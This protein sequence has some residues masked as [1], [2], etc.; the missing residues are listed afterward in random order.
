MMVHK[1]WSTKNRSTILNSDW[2]QRQ[3]TRVENG[4]SGAIKT[5]QSDGN[6]HGKQRTRDWGSTTK[7]PRRWQ[8]GE[9]LRVEAVW[10]H[11]RRLKQWQDVWDTGGYSGELRE[12][13]TTISDNA[14]SIQTIYMIGG[15]QSKFTRLWL[16]SQQEFDAALQVCSGPAELIRQNACVCKDPDPGRVSVAPPVD[17]RWSS[18]FHYLGAEGG[19]WKRI[20]QAQFARREHIGVHLL[21]PSIHRGRGSALAMCTVLQWPP[22]WLPHYSCCKSLATSSLH[23]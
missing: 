12:T 6:Q 14:A 21:Y 23:T 10:Q 1:W 13:W 19:N 11:K 18:K 16:G 7:Q 4:M 5:R 8:D 2:N 9:E 3:H 17:L 22:L 20:M 15:G